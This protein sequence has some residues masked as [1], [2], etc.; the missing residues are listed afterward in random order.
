MHQGNPPPTY[1]DNLLLPSTIP[2]S[3]DTNPF[4]LPMYALSFT[5]P[6]HPMF[7]YSMF[8][9]PKSPVLEA[10]MEICDLFAIKH[11]Q[12]GTAREGRHICA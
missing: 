4:T 9:R 12:V 3:T 8:I 2:F 1:P 10:R 6:P 7:L 5:P 11:N